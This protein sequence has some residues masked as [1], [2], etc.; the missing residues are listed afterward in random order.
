MTQ[1]DNLEEAASYI[2]KLRNKIE[3]LKQRKESN[4]QQETEDAT[5]PD[6]ARN[7]N[8]FRLPIIE[9]RYQNPNLEV[10]LITNSS[11]QKLT[12]H[13]VI[14]IIEE[15]GA[16]IVNASHSSLGDKLVYTVHS[17]VLFIYTFHFF[18][19]YF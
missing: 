4:L 2:I 18:L 8:M 13:K 19:S 17:Q 1:L 12:F 7:N 15:E 3:E 6:A 11:Y 16:E 10:V 9:V 14:R 5:A